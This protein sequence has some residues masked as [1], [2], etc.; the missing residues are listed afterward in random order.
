VQATAPGRHRAKRHLMGLSGARSKHWRQRV[1]SSRAMMR[2]KF[3]W[4]VGRDHF[5]G[6]MVDRG[7]AGL[8]DVFCKRTRA[9]SAQPGAGLVPPSRCSTGGPPRDPVQEVSQGAANRLP[10]R[11]FV[12]A[13]WVVLVRIPRKGNVTWIKDPGSKPPRGGPRSIL[14]NKRDGDRCSPTKLCRIAWAVRLKGA[15]FEL[16]RD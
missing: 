14:T 1:S 8:R 5:R 3:A 11:L 9:T 7:S 13:A 12:K 4:T 16:T 2:L 10:A 15:R 6:A